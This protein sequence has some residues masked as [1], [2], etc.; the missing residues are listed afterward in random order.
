MDPH[1]DYGFKLLIEPAPDVDGCWLAHILDIDV[2]SYGESFRHALEMGLEAAAM[3]VSDDVEHGRDPLERGKAPVEV[4]RR[5]AKIM[6]SGCPPL[7]LDELDA[8]ASKGEE[9]AAVFIVGVQF[10]RIREHSKRESF[11]GQPAPLEYVAA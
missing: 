4:Y 3:V 7:S 9:I 11:F 6:E 5:V 1:T 8:R 2:V 10:G